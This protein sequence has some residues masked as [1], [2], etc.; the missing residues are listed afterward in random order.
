M[1][2]RDPL[3]R[4]L[5]SQGRIVGSRVQKYRDSYFISDPRANT[6]ILRKSK[7]SLKRPPRAVFEGELEKQPAKRHGKPRFM[8]GPT[9]TKHCVY[10]Q[11]Q[12]FSTFAENRVLASFFTRFWILFDL[13]NDREGLK[14]PQKK[15]PR[16]QRK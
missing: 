13:Q 5:A 15:P 1:A 14:S 6:K 4:P 10:K 8:R 9:P 7:K 11:N 12:R 2:S 3:W 16:A